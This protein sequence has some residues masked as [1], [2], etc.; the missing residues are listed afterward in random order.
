M[1][2][3]GA[4]AHPGS[5]LW[6]ARWDGLAVLGMPTCG[7]FSQATT[8]DLVLPRILTGEPIGNREIAGLGHGG[9]LSREM[10]FRF[11]PYRANAARGE[12]E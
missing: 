7:M 5:L 11:P 12:L 10:A 8:F 6:L 9:L 1:E 2:R 3:H 4:P